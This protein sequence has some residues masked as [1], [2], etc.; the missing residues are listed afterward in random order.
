MKKTGRASEAAGPQNF[1]R[2]V[3]TALGL[4]LRLFYK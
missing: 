4:S 1:P 3:K 2:R